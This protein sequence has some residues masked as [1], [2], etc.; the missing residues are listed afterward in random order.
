MKYEVVVIGGGINGLSAL[1]HLARRG[2]KSLALVE[3]FKLGHGQGSSHGKSRITRSSYSSAKYV[4]LIQIAHSEEWPRLTREAGHELLTSTPGCFFGPGVDEYVKSMQAVTELENKFRVLDPKE[5]RR[6]FPMFRFPDSEQVIHDLTSSVVSAE[7]TMT[8]LASIAHRS[9]TVYESTA[10]LEIQTDRPHLTLLTNKGEIYCEQLVVTAGA[11]V[12]RLFPQFSPRFQVA[13]QD[14]GYFD[15][16]N[17]SDFPVWVY[18]ARGCD[19]FYGLPSFGRPG[20]KVARHRTGQ[21][22]DSPDREIVTTMP[23]QAL[24]QL[25]E[26]SREQF[27]RPGEL[28]GYEAC[29]YTNTV[30][31]DF[32]LDHYPD[33]TRIVVGSA[34]SGHGFK[35]GPLTGR[36]LSELLLD[37]K[38]GLELFERNR[39][40]FSWQSHKEW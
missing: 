12:G 40:A 39:T 16:P 29:L 31:E 30:N 22:N 19:S 23:A 8:F 21:E 24:T 4:E 34:C 33:D 13:H 27:T 9:A 35:F 3:Q 15:I 25:E 20:A 10:V 5:A 7:Q 11:W 37:G 1:Y 18:C 28:V 26:F 38:T 32:L 2:V 14:V 17:A 6:T 36:L